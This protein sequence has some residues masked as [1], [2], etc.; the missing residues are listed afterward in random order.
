MRRPDSAR[1][2]CCRLVIAQEMAAQM[3]DVR[4]QMEADEDLSA[5][6]AGLRGQNLD[7]NDFASADVDM[8]L[9][10]FD[11]SSAA[12]SE[13]GDALPLVYE[14]DQ[15]AAYW[16]KRSGAIA[17]RIVQL[18]G[19]SGTF[20]SS[21]ALDALRGTLKEN[22]VQRAIELRDIVTS[23]GPAYIKI[24]QALAIRPDL[25]SP[26]AM[27]ELQRLCDKVPSFDSKVAYDC[28][29]EE[30]GKPV[31]ELYAELTPEP[32]AAASLGQVYKG[33]LH[34]GEQVA[35]K[36]QR[37]FVLETV[38]C[39]L[40]VIRTIGLFM[41]R[42]PQLTERVD[43]V[44][45]LDEWA[46]RFFEEL[47]Y[48]REGQNATKFAEQMRYDLP[49]IVVPSTYS[50]LTSRKVLTSSWVDGE[51]LS[52]S[53]ASDVGD[54]VNVGVI[55][56]LKQLLE[57]G[58]FHADPHPG[59]LIRTPDG[60]LAVLDF[61]LMTQLD[62]DIKI[63]MIEAVAHLIH[64]DYDAIAEDFVSLQFID[65]GVDTGPIKPALARVFDAALAGGGA[66]GINFQDLAAD[67][68]QITFDFPFK[69][70]PYFAIV[71]RAIGVL[72]GIALTA[73]ENFAII[74]ESYPYLSKRLLTDDS[75]R[76][77]AAL[78]YMV[79]GR[80]STFDAERIIDLME[81]FET[82]SKAANSAMGDQGDGKD[83]ERQETMAPPTTA[84]VPAVG[85]APSVPMLPLPA[86][87]PVPPA[88]LP[89]PLPLP[90]GA[91]ADGAAF[92]VPSIG[93]TSLSSLSG[94][95]SSREALSFVLSE[96]GSFFRSFILEEVVKSVDAL[97]REQAALLAAQLG[98]ASLPIP[99]PLPGAINP[100]QLVPQVSAEERR[101]VESVYKIVSYLATDNGD[102][103][104]S[105]LSTSQ[106]AE[107][108]PFFPRVAQ[109][110]L[111]ELTSRLGN[112]IA[113]R[114]IREVF[115]VDAV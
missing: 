5:L 72:E 57:T 55:C 25:L 17:Q 47:D 64:R 42:F 53:K 45:L 12:A 76:L 52:Q 89:L 38:T 107:L 79:Y 23:L 100:L 10:N 71:I 58:N 2:A 22:E 48:V 44:A 46:S 19:V 110:V 39:D 84:L 114:A 88:G 30:L 3:R 35:V 111:P 93:G 96:E 15:I 102:A 68:A 77:R 41:R 63:G 36:V 70:P 115:L 27:V 51:K 49:Q 101:Q 83:G 104:G 54:L 21:L 40:Y 13:A 31:S 81:A 90:N 16:R 78:R 26:A 33:R 18:L 65:K 37:P 95:G 8:R 32:I 6:M 20:L 97:S 50:E 62:E 106:L 28:I 14:P 82:Y 1:R 103:A 34:T 98:V 69:I 92:A 80:S 87:L 85:A 112:R 113:A 24:G 109:E 61:G 108:V 7:E 75:P 74:D 99:V 43:V 60:K 56:Y 4:K 66:K 59:N 11:G 67:L 9:L 86:G 91:F 94:G 73:D 29:V 105:P